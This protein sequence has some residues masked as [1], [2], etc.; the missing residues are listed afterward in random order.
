MKK[1]RALIVQLTVIA[2][3]CLFAVLYLLA[4][5]YYRKGFGPGTYINDVYCTG[6]AVGQVN[7]ELK[8]LY[9]RESFFIQDASGQQYE[10]SLAEIGFKVDYTSQLTALQSRQNGLAWI[11]MLTGERKLELLPEISFDRAL[12]EKALGSCG[13]IEAN[14]GDETVEIRREQGYVLYD[15][16]KD[17]LA[18]DLVCDRVAEALQQNQLEISVADCYR[19]LPYSQEMLDTLALW[20]KVDAF[21]TC[22]IIY[23]MGDDQV[24]LTPAIVSQWIALDEDGSF[25]LD[26]SG[27]LVL[28]EEGIAA[29][30][31]NLC[32][33]YDTYG[34]TRTFQATRGDIITIEGG[35]YGNQLDRKAE[36]AYLTQAFLDKKQEVH[37][38]AYT[39]EAFVRGKND[40]GET[41]VEVDMTEQKLYYYEEGVLAFETDIVTGNLRRKMGTPSGVNFVYNK[42]R[43]RILRG[44]G[45]ASPVDY[46]VPVKGSIGIHDASWRKE[47]GGEIYQTNGSHGCINVPKERMGEL[48][49]MLEIGV[50]VVMF[51]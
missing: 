44:E 4:G 3:I 36:I 40:I 12:M 16:R 20:E 38:P 13:I 51:Y 19:N 29:F 11:T 37:I 33:E 17:V 45:Y 22:G 6:K 47:F 28:K 41:Y 9:D 10:V 35:T 1:K 8:D 30:I 50:P 27:N 43:N 46:W 31:D 26:E 18:M 25:L 48:Y 7:E 14:T 39:R 23:D 49:D 5:L 32:L 34:S 15:G 42:Q 2:G 21:Q 24:V